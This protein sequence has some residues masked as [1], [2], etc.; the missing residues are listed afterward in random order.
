LRFVFNRIFAHVA[1][2]ER[3]VTDDVL[4]EDTKRVLALYLEQP[5]LRQIKKES[6]RPACLRTSCSS[7]VT[8]HKPLSKHGERSKAARQ[9]PACVSRCL[10]PC[11][12]APAPAL[13]SGYHRDVQGH[14]ATSSTAS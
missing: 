10:G 9:K 2:M 4:T 1:V 6:G 12:L 13:R 11:A 8:T 5:L 14:R 3:K 7:L